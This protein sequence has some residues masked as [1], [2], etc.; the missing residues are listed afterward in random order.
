MHVMKYFKKPWF[1][2]GGWV[3]DIALGRVTREHGDIDICIFREDVNEA[4]Q[5]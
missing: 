5:L 2:A 3:I 1:I 4:L